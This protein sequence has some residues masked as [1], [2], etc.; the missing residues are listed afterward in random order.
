[1]GLL[2]KTNPFATRESVQRH[3]II[4]GVV[5]MMFCLASI[6]WSMPEEPNWLLIPGVGVLCAAIAALAEWQLD[7]GVK[8]YEVLL[9]IDDEFAIELPKDKE[10]DT[11]G[12]MY[13]SILAIRREK[14]RSSVDEIDTWERLKALLVKQLEIKPELVT[15]DARFYVDI[16]M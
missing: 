13:Q 14:E 8:F 10:L 4:G 1:M 6:L 5:G 11:I 15:P 3:A 16:R 9:E 12:D 2:D 7:D